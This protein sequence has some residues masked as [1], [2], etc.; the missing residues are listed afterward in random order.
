MTGTC[1]HCGTTIQLGTMQQHSL[2]F[3]VTHPHERYAEAVRD[4]CSPECLY[5]AAQAV[6]ASMAPEPAPGGGQGGTVS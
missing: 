3:T 1:A 4:T 5:A 2:R 6:V